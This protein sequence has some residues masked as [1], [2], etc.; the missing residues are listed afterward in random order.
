MESDENPGG[1]DVVVLLFCG[2]GGGAGADSFLEA[3]LDGGEDG[4]DVDDVIV[5][6]DSDEGVALG[7]LRGPGSGGGP[8]ASLFGGGGGV[9][10][11]LFGVSTSV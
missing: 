1:R 9:G 11:F 8:P 7:S 2:G 6:V 10:V 4:D 3:G 5:E